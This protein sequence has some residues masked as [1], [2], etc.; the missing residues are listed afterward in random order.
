MPIAPVPWLVSAGRQT[1]QRRYVSISGLH[2][3]LLCQMFKFKQVGGP[4]QY[5][6]YPSAPYG[7][8]RNP[9]R[10]A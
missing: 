8:S 2:S 4:G 1:E 5:S 9:S 10:S 6:Q 3:D 7:P